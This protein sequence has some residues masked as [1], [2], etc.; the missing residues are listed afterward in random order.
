MVPT[1]DGQPWLALD[2]GLLEVEVHVDH[3]A[4]MN[5]WRC[6]ERGLPLLGQIHTILQEVAVGPSG[7]NPL[8][9]NH[10]EPHEALE[11]T[12]RGTRRIR[13][14]EPSP[15]EARLADAA[16]ELA[17]LVA[18]AEKDLVSMLPRQ[19]VHGDF[20]DNNVGFREGRVVLV[21]DFDFMG[22][23][24]RIDD[25]ALCL[26]FTS[27]KYAENPVSDDQLRRLRRL[28]DAYDSGLKD[29]LSDAERAALALAMARQPL[30]SIGGW[31]ALLDD[32]E[33]A[34]Q[35]AAGTFGAVQWALG[36]MRELDRW[37]TAF[38]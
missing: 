31:V 11:R 15:T 14:W 16:E 6:L 3:D 38:L 8:F 20:W 7:R 4:D 24:A 10:I 17:H 18:A 33:T 30:W 13:S 34:R 27:M 12:F 2:G 37:Q 36:I 28:V 19:L 21:T 5:S 22:E 32:G 26:Y 25:L 35:H 1:L 23:R 29:P 9:A